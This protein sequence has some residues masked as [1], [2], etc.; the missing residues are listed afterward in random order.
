MLILSIFA[1]CLTIAC[2]LEVAMGVHAMTKIGD[3]P[4]LLKNYFPKVSVIIPA[5]NEAKTIKPALLS[6]LNLAYPNLEIIIVNDRSTDSTAKVIHQTIQGAANS[7]TVIDITE[8]SDNWMGKNHALHVGALRAEGEY[9]LFTDADIVMEETVLSRAM[10]YMISNKLDHLSMFFESIAKGGLLNALLMDVG[11]G[12]LLL[13]KPWKVRNPASRNF[14]GVGAFNL[15]KTSAYK[16]IGGHTSFAMHPIDDIMLGK[17]IKRNGFHQDCLIGLNHVKV[18]WY[19]TIKE[20]IDGVMKNTFAVYDY[21]II[22]VAFGIS[23]I[24]LVNISP[25]WGSITTTGASQLI[26]FCSVMVR[27]LF[28]AH[29]FSYIGQPKVH[30]FWSL[31]SPYINIYICLKATISTLTCQG[32]KWRG[33]L[34]PL[35]QIQKQK[36]FD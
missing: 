6:V 35:Q 8:L 7:L 32:I 24:L 14:M 3:V 30:A 10:H 19:S 13:F 4:M 31:I 20:M 36:F 33:T 12:L 11:G 28:F 16:A 25:V 18:K 34:Y 26:F 17:I 15:V 27:L 29:G 1:L 21:S 5:R 9:L 23:L 22:R 2:V